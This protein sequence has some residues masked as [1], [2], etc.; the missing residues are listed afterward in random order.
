MNMNR[1]KLIIVGNGATADIA[2]E[3]FTYDSDFEVVG[4]SV[5]KDFRNSQSYKNLPI[6]DFEDI[7]SS[8]SPKNHF[9]YVAISFNQFNRLRTRFYNASKDRGYSIASYISSKAFVWQN[10][11]IGENCFIFENNTVQ[12]FVNVGNNVT[13]WSGNHIGHHS[14]ISDNCF[15]SSEV[16][17]SGFCEVGKNCFIGVNSTIADNVKIGEDN[18]IGPGLT[19]LKDTENNLIFG[20]ANAQPSKIPAKKFFKIK[21]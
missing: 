17:V 21:E 9:I 2:Y 1:K 5:E 8:F 10:V 7:H 19:I 6:V 4:F 11:V 3:Y 13:L 16:V 12:P 15:I 14:K 18:W 20:S